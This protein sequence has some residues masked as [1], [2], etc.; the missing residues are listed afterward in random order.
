MSR[1]AISHSLTLNTESCCNCG[2]VF[3]FPST[4]MDGLRTT[5][6]SFYCPNGH[7]QHY[8]KTEVDRL[9]EK[10]AEQTRQ[11]TAMAATANDMANRARSAEEKADKS[12]KELARIKKRVSAGVCPC[13]DRTFQ[14]LQR[15]MS[16]QHKKGAV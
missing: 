10:L 15:H 8:T 9:K 5:G 14:N 11:A 12:S 3:A 2:I 16:T 1:H 7:G 13:C 6:G 4:L